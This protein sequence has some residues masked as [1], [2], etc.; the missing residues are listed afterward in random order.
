MHVVSVKTF[1]LSKETCTGRQA[2]AEEVDLLDILLYNGMDKYY[3]Y[4]RKSEKLSIGPVAWWLLL[5][6]LQSSGGR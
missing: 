4:R 3:P 2:S 5:R 1:L 6:L